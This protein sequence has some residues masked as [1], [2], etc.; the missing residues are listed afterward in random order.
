M[1]S[2]QLF[3]NNAQGTLASGINNAATSVTLGSGEGARFGTIGANQFVRATLRNSTGSVIE[4]VNITAVVG[5]VLTIVRAQEGTTA[6]SFAA[7]STV[8]ARWTAAGADR[9]T[10]RDADEAITGAWTFPAPSAA[11]NPATKSYVDTPPF[12][13]LTTEAALADADTF[14]F[15][16]ASA[17]APRRVTG[18]NLRA[19]IGRGYFPQT[20]VYLY[21]SVTPVITGLAG[22]AWR[23]IG[24]FGNCTEGY[25]YGN[26][27]ATNW[28][29][30]PGE[31]SHWL[32]NIELVLSHATTFPTNTTAYLAA[33]RFT[34]ANVAQN[35]VVGAHVNTGSSGL[36]YIYMSTTSI[37]PFS[38]ATD[39]IAPEVFVSGAINY[40]LYSCVV[41]AWKIN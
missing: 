28:K 7:G 14:P 24:G 32:I 22:N 27:A 20:G 31:T 6:Q 21:G 17:A 13:L 8:S 29:I 9:M 36:S 16:D 37:Q 15:Y 26:K 33:T 39:Y 2:R 3:V 4:I 19:D 40:N 25:D 38:N 11:G 30:T 18:A 41:H 35:Q 34:S 10:Q 5:D 12:Q 1:P 23:N